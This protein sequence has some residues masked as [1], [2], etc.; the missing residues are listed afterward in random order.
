[1]DSVEMEGPG[2]FLTILGVGCRH[3]NIS[4]PDQLLGRVYPREVHHVLARNFGG[5]P[6]VI[7]KCREGPTCQLSGEG[8][9]VESL[10]F[11]GTLAVT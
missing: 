4:P 5:S 10:N 6:M 1:M 8:G 11:H 2:E 3:M 9:L 7:C